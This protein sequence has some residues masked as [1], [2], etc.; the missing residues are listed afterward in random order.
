MSWGDR[1]HGPTETSKWVRTVT[2][3]LHH[4]LL[5]RNG[6]MGRIF[7]QQHMKLLQ[8]DGGEAWILDSGFWRGQKQQRL[9]PQR[10][11]VGG[12]G[13]A[14]DS[15]GATTGLHWSLQQVPR[16]RSIIIQI[17]NSFYFQTPNENCLAWANTTLF[18]ICTLLYVAKKGTIN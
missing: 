3:H 18:H 5:L 14:D 4:V 16:V 2:H 9:E 12:Q 11:E 1:V 13:P 7:Q 8:T 6:M 17:K 15:N 10:S